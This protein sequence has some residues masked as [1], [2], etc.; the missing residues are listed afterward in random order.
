MLTEAARGVIAERG[1]HAVTLR[2]VAAAGGVAVGTVTYHFQGM[3]DVL[4]EVLRTEMAEF[5]APILARA[6]QTGGRAGLDLVIDGLLAS[7]TATHDHWM[8]WLDFWALAARSP[9]YAAWQAEVYRDLHALVR[10]C[11]PGQG[12]RN[13]D[14]AVEFVAL[15]DG[16]VVQCYLPGGP[17]TPARG[18]TIL[19]SFLTA[20]DG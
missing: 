6:A 11:L 3:A 10:A 7:D 9:V 15:L 12:G 20:M 14:R 8:L 5:S 1:L 18:R 19:R 13:A 4:A 2:D 17:L 16:L